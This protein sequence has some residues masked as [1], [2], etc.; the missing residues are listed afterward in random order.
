[1]CTVETHTEDGI[2][3]APRS[4]SR[5]PSN[6]REK[7]S[8]DLVGVNPRYGVI[9]ASV[10]VGNHVCVPVPVVPNEISNPIRMT[11]FIDGLAREGNAQRV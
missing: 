10:V 7:F 3:G 4:P 5:L 8:G 2:A 6:S 9:S 1:M 11:G